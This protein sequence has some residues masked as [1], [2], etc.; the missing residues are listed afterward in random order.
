MPSPRPPLD[1]LLA[2]P[3]KALKEW[4][5]AC[6]ALELGRQSVLLRKGGIVEETRD[7]AL[8]EARFPLFPTFEHQDPESVQ[9]A[10]RE[11][12]PEAIDGRHEQAG[13]VRISAWA[14]VT[15]LYLVEDLEPVLRLSSLHPWTE[16][17]VRMRMAYK[18]R[19]PMNVVVVR[20]YLLPSPVDLPVL[21]YFAGCKSWVPLEREIPLDGDRPALADDEHAARAGEVERLLGSAASRVLDPVYR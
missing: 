2:A 11:L 21:D 6:R 10:Y 13:V 12:F 1:P 15:G 14:E 19:K 20:T 8:V 18:P 17:Y 4:A 16:E 7:F 3:Q 5:V 9:P